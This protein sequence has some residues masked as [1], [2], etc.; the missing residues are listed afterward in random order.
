MS[1]W[2]IQD[3]ALVNSTAAPKNLG[4][5]LVC[6]KTLIHYMVLRPILNSLIPSCIPINRRLQQQH[7]LTCL[8]SSVNLRPQ[9]SSQHAKDCQGAQLTH[10]GPS[11]LKNVR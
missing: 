8:A 3:T 1:C 5:G 9:I 7:V 4:K 6:V 11:D 10:T 2:S